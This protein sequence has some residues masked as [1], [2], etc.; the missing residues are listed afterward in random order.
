MLGY[1]L[2]HY[3]CFQGNRGQAGTAV[4]E[5]EEE[6]ELV[7]SLVLSPVVY[8]FLVFRDIIRGSKSKNY[9]RSIVLLAKIKDNYGA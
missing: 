5:E 1:H 6:E 3:I 4:K 8:Y 2:H 7:L 9:K